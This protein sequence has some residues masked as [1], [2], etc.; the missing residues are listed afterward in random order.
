MPNTDAILSTLFDCRLP[1]PFSI[2]DC[3]CIGEIIVEV[4]N[5]MLKSSPGRGANEA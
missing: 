5:E 3:E 4:A 2:A 1:L